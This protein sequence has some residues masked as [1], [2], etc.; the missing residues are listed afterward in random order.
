MYTFKL[1]MNSTSMNSNLKPKF[2]KKKREKK[3]KE[4]TKEK[5]RKPSWAHSTCFR[6]N[7]HSREHA[8]PASVLMRTLESDT[9]GPHVSLALQFLSSPRDLPTWWSLSLA[10]AFLAPT[11]LRDPTV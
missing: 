2:E 6:P 8:G 4:N 1:S 3:R 7:S 5:E 11:D 9:R 10:P